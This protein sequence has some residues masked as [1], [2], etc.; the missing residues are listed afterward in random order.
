MHRFVLGGVIQRTGAMV[1]PMT[2]PGGI[3]G[4]TPGQ[5][6]K[7]MSSQTGPKPKRVIA[8]EIHSSKLHIL[9]C[10][11][12]VFRHFVMRDWMLS[13][14]YWHYSRSCLTGT[15]FFFI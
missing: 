8:V 13:F 3:Q 6:S 12:R 14:K 4:L 11:C 1:M 15:L 7:T 9:K 2:T 10:L 5:Q